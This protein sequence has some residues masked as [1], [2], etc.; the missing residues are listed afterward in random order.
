MSLP[1]AKRS[2]HQAIFFDLAIAFLLLI[3]FISVYTSV[4]LLQ[5]GLALSD[6]FRLFL[7]IV[8]VVMG[9]GGTL[10]FWGSVFEPNIFIVRRKHFLLGL[11]TPLKIAIASDFHI[12][13]YRK[14]SFTQKIVR[15]LNALNADIILLPGD[16]LDDEEVPLTDLEPLKDLKARYG[17]FAVTGNHDAGAYLKQWTHEPYFNKDRTPELEKMLTSYGIHFLRNSSE[18]L[19]IKNEDLIIAGTDDAHMK[20][21]DPAKTFAGLPDNL[22]LI[23]L[24]HT[25]DVLLEEVTHRANLIVSG[26]THGGQIRLPFI[27]SLLPMPDKLGRAFQRGFFQISEN[28]TLFITEGIGATGVRARLF[29]P[30]E[31]MLLETA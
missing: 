4:L 31:I 30:P 19:R 26:H 5:S 23:L 9:L 29:C 27:G 15:Q 17:V 22:P 6:T 28:C 16:F 7:L 10:T 12:G 24:S 14:K 18:T 13:I 20:S 11:R 8:I 1:F 3:S 21:F 2:M 25:P